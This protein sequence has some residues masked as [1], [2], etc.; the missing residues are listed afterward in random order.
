MS[1]ATTL[2]WD[3][4]NLYHVRN[5]KRTKWIGHVSKSLFDPTWEV[6]V[7]ATRKHI[8]SDEA[9]ARKQLEAYAK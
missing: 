6:W 8:M 9:S 3:G 7:R 5:G 2:E 1:N 4:N